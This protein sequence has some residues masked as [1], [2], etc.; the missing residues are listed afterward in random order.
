MIMMITTQMDGVEPAEIEAEIDEDDFPEL[1][2]YLEQSEE[3]DLKVELE[4]T[5][6]MHMCLI[7]MWHHLNVGRN[8]P[9]CELFAKP[10]HSSSSSLKLGINIDSVPDIPVSD[11][12]KFVMRNGKRAR[13]RRGITVDSGARAT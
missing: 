6:Y 12:V 8:D 11:K 3:E 4:N 1:T 9:D 2:T 10:S 13:L 7:M 5:M